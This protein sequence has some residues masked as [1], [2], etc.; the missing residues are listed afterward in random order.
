MT[1]L[2]HLKFYRFAGIVEVS[3]FA[4]YVMARKSDSDQQQKEFVMASNQQREDN[5]LGFAVQHG[6]V[7][8]LGTFLEDPLT[9]PTR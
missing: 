3:V 9:V 5:R 1:G 8:Y 7:R 6:T 2:I 4:R